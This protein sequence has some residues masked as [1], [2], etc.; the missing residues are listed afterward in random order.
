MSSVKLQFP[1]KQEVKIRL[2][3]EQEPGLVEDFLKTVGREIQMVCNHLVC[4]G[5][6]FDAYPR[7]S[8]EA[9][10]KDV[11]EKTENSQLTAGDVLWDGEKMTIVYGDVY[12][13]GTAGTIIG[14]AEADKEFIKACKS[15][16]FDLFREHRVSVITVSKE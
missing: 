7:F 10:V 14:K 5:E 8:A 11:G 1:T 4:A 9:S 3:E 15:I 2:F 12:A 16:W 13:P 6:I